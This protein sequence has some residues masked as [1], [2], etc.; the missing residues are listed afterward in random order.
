MQEESVPVHQ[1]ESGTTDPGNC[2]M[3]SLGRNTEIFDVISFEMWPTC[4]VSTIYISN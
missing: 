1:D 2:Q 3:S 4:L